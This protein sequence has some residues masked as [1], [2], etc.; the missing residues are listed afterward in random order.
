MMFAPLGDSALVI[1][2]PGGMAPETM[3]EAADLAAR[4][5]E[6]NLPGVH[7]VIVAYSSVAVYFDPRAG[8]GSTVCT[9]VRRD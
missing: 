9:A 5:V 8:R 2:L 7:D 3:D 6:A 4:I 1:T